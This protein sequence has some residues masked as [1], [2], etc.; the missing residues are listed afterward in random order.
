MRIKP[1]TASRTIDR[2]DIYTKQYEPVQIPDDWKIALYS[3][4]MDEQINCVN[5]GKP[6]KYGEG[7]TSRR[8]H[9][10]AGM[11]YMECEDCYYD[12]LKADMYLQQRKADSGI[13]ASTNI[14]AAEDDEFEDP[15]IN[16]VD[17]LHDRVSDDFDYVM[18]GIERLGREGMLDEAI[19]LLNTL[20]DTLDSAIGIIGNDFESGSTPDEEV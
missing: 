3:D 5:C 16:E 1:I 17:E 8:Y 13:E 15:R 18:T 4:N 19:S 9:N 6:M 10:K 2:W 20:A 7:Y 12:Q 14:M 11:G